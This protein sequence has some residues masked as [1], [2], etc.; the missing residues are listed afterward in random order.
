MTDPKIIKIELHEYQFTQDD[1][2]TDYNDFNLVYAPGNT[3]TRKGYII[4]IFTDSGLIGEY[5]GGS[6]AEYSTLPRFAHYLIGK[7]ALERERIYSD[8]KRALRQVARIG[9]APVDTALWDLA[10]NP[11]EAGVDRSLLEHI[12]PFRQRKNAKMAII[13]EI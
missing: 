4:R 11:E 7:N 9:M 2:G 6:A 5:A 13:S 12:S 3:I 8:V 1:L 10:G